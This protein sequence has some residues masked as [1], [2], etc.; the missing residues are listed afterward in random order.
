[1]NN[2]KKPYPH[3]A[4]EHDYCSK[5]RHIYCYLQ[6]GRHMGTKIKR[7]MN[8]RFRSSYKHLLHEYQKELRYV[9]RTEVICYSQHQPDF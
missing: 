4:A 3:K 5:W 8:Q 2:S 6:N 9:E 1:M 7:Q